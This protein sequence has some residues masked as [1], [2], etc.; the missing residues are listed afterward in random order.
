LSFHRLLIAANA[1]IGYVEVKTAGDVWQQIFASSTSGGHTDWD[2]SEES[3][4]VASYADGN[5]NFQIRF[6]LRSFIAS[7]FAPG[8]NVDRLI[9]RDGSLPEFDACGGCAGAP[10][11]AGVLS[12][13]DDDPCADSGVTLTWPAAP[14]WGTGTAGTYAVYRGT[15]ASFVPGPG[16]LLA[17]GISGTGW[18]DPAPPSG[19]TLYYLV[20]AENDETCSTG[21]A[22]GGVTDANIAYASAINATGQPVPGAVGHTL[23]VDKVNLA[24]ARLAWSPAP[25]AAAYHVYRSPAP[26]GGFSGIAAPVD[27]LFEDQWALTD[28]EGWYYLVRSADACGNEE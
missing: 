9:L 16:N 2:W 12:A 10:T 20:R 8:W 5:S 15:T 22:N 1:S 25:E 3:Y 13:M 23:R 4:N 7:S 6:R 28:A 26:D 21:P 11:F 19:V 18:T 17:S 24:H 27:A 14:A